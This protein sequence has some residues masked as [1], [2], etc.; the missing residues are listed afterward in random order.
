MAKYRKK[1]VVVEAYQ[2]DNRLT[3]VP[4]F[5]LTQA[6][7]RGNVTHPAGNPLTCSINTPEGQIVAQEGDWIIQ[8]FGGLHP[9]KPDIFA[10]TYE[11]VEI[12]EGGKLA[13]GEEGK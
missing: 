12:S 2:L 13:I 9:C 5:W 1:P 6:I 8:G 4:P 11:P 10:A 7:D 3:N